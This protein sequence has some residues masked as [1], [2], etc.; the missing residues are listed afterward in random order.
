[1]AEIT[2]LCTPL[3]AYGCGAWFPG[4]RRSGFE[5]YVTLASCPLLRQH[6]ARKTSTKTSYLSQNIAPPRPRRRPPNGVEAPRREKVKLAAGWQ[7]RAVRVHSDVE[8][9]ASLMSRRGVKHKE[10]RQQAWHV[11][12]VRVVGFFL[13]TPREIFSSTV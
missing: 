11:P 13:R 6:K 12:L 7:K 3:L 10:V 1:L 5:F 9:Q 8:A 2:P 4:V